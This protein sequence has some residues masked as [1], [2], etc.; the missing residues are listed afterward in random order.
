MH[1]LG[2]CPAGPLYQTGG[3]LTGLW[4]RSDGIR[5]STQKELLAHK[6][7]LQ[8]VVRREFHHPI[9]SLERYANNGN[10]SWNQLTLVRPDRIA[11]VLPKCLP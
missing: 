5:P 6:M 2:M 4:Q 8:N 7:V 11:A 3:V 10:I 9:R 1:N